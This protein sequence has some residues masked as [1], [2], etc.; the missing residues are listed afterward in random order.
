[1][2][3]DPQISIVLTSHN[4]AGTIRECLE[5]ISKNTFSVEMEILLIDDRSDDGTKEAALSAEAQNLR[6]FRIDKYQNP[7]LTARQAAL[8]LG[9]REARGEYIF[10][11]NADAI[12]PCDWIKRMYSV[13]KEKNVDAVAGQIR[14][15]SLK[16]WIKI[17]QTVDAFFYFSMCR[18]RNKLGINSGIFFGN[19]VF[20]KSAYEKIGGF[21]RIGFSFTEDLSFSEWMHKKGLSKYYLKKPVVSVPACPDLKALAQRTYRVSASRFS[22]FS[23]FIWSWLASLPALLIPAV[24]GNPIFL[25]VF[26]VRYG[27][28]VLFIL[29]SSFRIFRCSLLPV[30]LFYEWIA[31]AFGGIVMFKH[32][33]GH[34]VYWGGILYDR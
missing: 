11:T 19:F 29:L 17:L 8:D 33:A 25:K 21:K 16:G 7:N 26:F 5:S 34:K 15:R 30:T 6:V 31:I 9:F 3:K 14:F 27:L 1:M 22:L 13:L 2:G 24:L 28:G 18:L 32:L 4:A 20:K 12:V 23:L 10:I